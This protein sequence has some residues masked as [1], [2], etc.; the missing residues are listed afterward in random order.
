MTKKKK[1]ATTCLLH[2]VLTWCNIIITEQ[3]YVFFTLSQKYILNECPSAH[4]VAVYIHHILDQTPT[5]VK[6]T[7]VLTE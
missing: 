3:D 1:H 6:V 4:V 2:V 5:G 7:P